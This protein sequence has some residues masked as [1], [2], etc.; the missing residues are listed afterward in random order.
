MIGSTGHSATLFATHDGGRSWHALDPVRSRLATSRDVSAALRLP[1]S[2]TA[3]TAGPDG[4]LYGAYAKQ[5]NGGEQQVVRFDPSTGAEATSSTIQGGAAGDDRLAFAGRSL[6]AAGGD[7]FRTASSRVLY[8]MDPTTLAVRAKVEMP[9]PPIALASVTAGL[10]VAAGKHLVLLDPS[11]GTI[12]ETVT[13]PGVV[14]NLVSDPNG[15]R[16]YVSTDAPVRHDTTPLLELDA[17]TGAAI[18]RTWQGYA[19]L[20]GVAGLAATDEGV[21]VTVP[22]GMMATLFFLRAG[23]LEKTSTYEPG[24][25]NGLQAFVADGALWAANLEGGYTCADPATGA[26]H[27]YVG[28]SGTPTGTSRVVAT[29][30]GLFVGGGGGIDRIVPPPACLAG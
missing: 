20:N 11:T 14:R 15:G 6:W 3:L 23:E 21:W 10:W 27:G 5:I 18:A 7:P 30:S 2:V 24:G 1:R 29:P 19:D 25:S 26:V 12:R 17:W 16:L 9:A 28:I 8:E 13:F 22:T 4:V